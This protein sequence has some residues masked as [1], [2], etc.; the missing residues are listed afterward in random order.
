MWLL[1][2]LSSVKGT[3]SKVN[4]VME[5]EKMTGPPRRVISKVMSQSL[6]CSI[7]PIFSMKGTNWMM[8][9]TRSVSS[10]LVEG[11]SNFLGLTSPMGNSSKSV[12]A[13]LLV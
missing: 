9:Q 2:P 8:D 4:G 1:T 7:Q 10:S 12:E 11:S 5:V 13:R 6:V 3:F